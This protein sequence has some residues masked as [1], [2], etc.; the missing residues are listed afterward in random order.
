MT[1]DIAF[2]KGPGV[3]DLAVS[4]REKRQAGDMLLAL[5]AGQ[6]GVDARIKTLRR[7]VVCASRRSHPQGRNQ[8]QTESSPRRME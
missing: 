4:D 1:A 5:R 8:G 6:D 7:G 3:D 2:A